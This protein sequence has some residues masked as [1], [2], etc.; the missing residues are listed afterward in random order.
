LLD[1]KLGFVDPAYAFLMHLLL[2]KGK[3][4]G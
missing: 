1:L 2:S 3:I 4:G